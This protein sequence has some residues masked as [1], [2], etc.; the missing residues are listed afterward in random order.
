MDEFKEKAKVVLKRVKRGLP[1]LIVG[2]VIIVL[3]AGFTYITTL[4]DGLYEEDDWSST[5]YAASTFT[6][7][8]TINEDGTISF[9]TTAEELWN[10]M[11][12]NGSNVSQYLD[13]P[14]ELERLMKAELVT[15]YPDTRPNPDEEIDWDSIINGD[16]LQGIIKFIR[17]DTE[18]NR[19]TMTYVDQETFQSY[20]DEYNKTGSPTAKQNALSH[21]QVE[22]LL[23][24]MDQI[25][26]G[27]Q[28]QQQ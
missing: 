25:Y 14:E 10:K 1:L 23:I 3:L 15:Q 21:F 7:S 12:E 4:K 8:A 22:E 18:G 19:S 20:I 6:N 16:S 2:V 26:V 5:P 28:H 11:I 13:S 27:Q 9:S 17:A 24:I